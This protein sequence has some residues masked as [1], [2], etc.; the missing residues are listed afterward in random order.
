MKNEK[1]ISRNQ[2]MPTVNGNIHVVRQTCSSNRSAKYSNCC[3]TK[4]AVSH[5][6]CKY[7]FRLSTKFYKGTFGRIYTY[8]SIPGVFTR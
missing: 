1:S 4:T 5:A 3:S 6:I 8:Q 7:E 2:E